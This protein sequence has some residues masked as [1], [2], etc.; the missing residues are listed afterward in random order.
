MS[1]R[2]AIPNPPKNQYAGIAQSVEQLIRNQQ[3]ACSS[4]VSSS[5]NRRKSDDFC[6]FCHFL[7]EYS[8]GQNVGQTLTHT[9]TH[10]PKQP[11]R[12]GEDI[13]PLRPF[14]LLCVITPAP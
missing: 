11:E 2:S 6:R 4:H 8:V 1:V 10:K 13:R 3:V 5:T 14:L 12:A 7:M 9:M